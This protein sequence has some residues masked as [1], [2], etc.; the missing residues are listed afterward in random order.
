MH[1]LIIIFINAKSSPLKHTTQALLYQN[2]AEISG[3]KPLRILF[4][5]VK[6]LSKLIRQDWIV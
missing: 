6:K 4:E 3:L 2:F 5:N 1:F